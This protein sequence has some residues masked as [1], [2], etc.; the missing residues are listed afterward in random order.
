[1]HVTRRTAFT[2]VEL[3]VV[4]TIIALLVAILL[5]SLKKSRDQAKRT[6]CAAHLKQIAT[7]IWSYG[8]ETGGRLPHVI[9]PMTNGTGT[10]LDGQPAPGFGDPNIPD[11]E[12]DPFN[13]H[14]QASAD[15]KKGWPMSLPNTLMPAYLGSEEGVFTCPAARRGWPRQGG[16]IRMA[17]RPAAAN[18]LAGTVPAPAVLMA[19]QFDYNRDH[20]GF[21]DGRM[22][23]PPVPVRRLGTDVQSIIREA[24]ESAILRGTF[25][26]DLVEYKVDHFEGPHRGGVNV[27]NKRLEV[28]FRDQKVIDADLTPNGVRA[29]D[30]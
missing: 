16:P 8:S 27:I 14:A 25:A 10:D 19:G 13:R 15:H 20:F 30:F 23:R 5:P 24:L 17:Y 22:Y 9:S 11:D 12:V 2:L 7:A 4:V 1:M 6:L 26:R 29:V 18:Q 28:E 21:L 3:L